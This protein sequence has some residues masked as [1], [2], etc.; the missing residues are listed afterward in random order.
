MNRPDQ[1]RPEIPTAAD[2]RFWQAFVQAAG[3]DD[4]L[5]ELA[6]SV[7]IDAEEAC[8]SAFDSGEN[9]AAEDL[10]AADRLHEMLLA[11]RW[12]PVE[13]ATVA[14]ADRDSAAAV[15]R[16]SRRQFGW[17]AAL[18]LVTLASVAAVATVL[19]FGDDET[20]AGAAN[21][22]VA[23][24][25]RLA[26]EW[27]ALREE[28]PPRDLAFAPEVELDAEPAVDAFAFEETPDWLVLAMIRRAELATDAVEEAGP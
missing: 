11:A 2:E 20:G 3:F 13:P 27:M 26:E 15:G 23:S 10:L 28:A 25:E 8:L 6:A 22:E 5:R 16:D 4:E 24:A 7:E 19:F 14:L 12:A 18:S 21:A 17:L 9:P 1:E